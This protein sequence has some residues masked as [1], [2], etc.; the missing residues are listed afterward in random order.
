MWDGTLRIGEGH[1]THRLVEGRPLMLGGVA[2]PHDRGLDGHSDADVLLHA[3]TDAVL[4]AAGI[5]DI[6]DWFP[7]T[8]DA[9]AGADSGE[10]LQTVVEQINHRGWFIGNLDCTVFAEQPKLSAFKAPIRS[11]IAELL[12]TSTDNVNVKAKSGE[13]VGPV[14]REEAIRASAVVL[15]VKG[16]DTTE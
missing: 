11:R 16:R 2:I 7:N 12:N 15:I 1:D 6:G 3:I 8:D 5:G 13:G 10:L 14:G 9:Y 4:G